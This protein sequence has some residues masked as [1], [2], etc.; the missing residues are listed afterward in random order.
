MAEHVQPHHVHHSLLWSATVAAAVSIV[1]VGRPF[2][3][4]AELDALNYSAAANYTFGNTIQVDSGVASLMAVDQTDDAN[5]A[6]GFDGGSH[7][8][9]EWETGN[10][11]LELAN[12]GLVAGSGVFTSRVIDGLSEVSW[13]TLRW[14]SDRP[15]SKPLPDGA[16]IETAYASG[17]VDM[18]D[19]LLLMHLDGDFVI[20]GQ[21]MVDNSDNSLNGIITTNDGTTN[22]TTAGKIAAAVSLDGVDDVITVPDTALLDETDV[23]TIEAWVDWN[24]PNEVW[25]NT[26]WPQRKEI[27]ISSAA[28][29]DLI[30]FPHL[31]TV[32]YESEMQADYD[33]LRFVSGACDDTGGAVL[34]HEVEDAGVAEAKVWVKLPSL[35]TTTGATVCMYYGDATASNAEDAAGVWDD[36]FEMVLHLNETSGDYI[37][38]T[39]NSNDAAVTGSPTRGAVGKVAGAVEFNNVNNERIATSGVLDT[40]DQFTISTWANLS[41]TGSYQTS[42]WNQATSGGSWRQIIAAHNNGNTYSWFNGGS[43]G[44]N[45]GMNPG[46][47]SWHY[48]VF[49]YDGSDIKV[50]RDGVLQNTLTTQMNNS[51]SL[52]HWAL[53]DREDSS[54]WRTDGVIDEYR[55]STTERDADWITHSYEM[56][57]NAGLHV[58][59]GSAE[60]FAQQVIV[61]KGNDA[62]SLAIE[63]GELVGSVN[64][65]VVSAAFTEGWNHVAL[66]YDQTDLRLFLN[67]TQVDAE[68]LTGLIATNSTDLT[69]GDGLSGELDEVAVYG[70][71]LTPDEVQD[72]YLRNAQQ[73]KFQV[74][75]CDDV[76]C[77]TEPF[78][79]PDGTAA[80]YYTEIESDSLGLPTVTIDVDDNR[81]VQYQ[82]TMG[83]TDPLQNVAVSSV[84]LGPTHYDG[85]R[86]SIV[87]VNATEFVGLSGFVETLGSGSQGS[88]EYQLSA[89]GV[90]WYY[91]NGSAWVVASS[92]SQANSAAAVHSAIGTFASTV[93][94]GS[95]YVQAVLVSADGMQPVELDDISITYT[96]NNSP[97]LSTLPDYILAPGESV[98][99]MLDEYTT[100]ADGDAIAYSLATPTNA[101][102][103]TTSFN[104]DTSQLTITAGDTTGKVTSL[105][106]VATD[107]N[108]AAVTS[109]VVAV[110]VVVEDTVESGE[111]E[112]ET[113]TSP[114][115]PT[116]LRLKK[117]T[118]RKA[119]LRWSDGA[120]DTTPPADYYKVQI[121]AA[122]N[123]AIKADTLLCYEAKVNADCYRIGEQ[124]AK[125]TPNQAYTFAVQACYNSGE[126]SAYSESRSF[127]TKPNRVKDVQFSIIEAEAQIGEASF[128]PA[129]GSGLTYQVQLRN[130]KN[131]KTITA[132]T[133][134]ETTGHLLR[135]PADKK[136][137]LRI[138]AKYNDANVGKWQKQR[139]GAGL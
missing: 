25:F 133:S 16:Q 92:T 101:T 4:Q 64:N 90:T 49:A 81:Y 118:V 19:N 100:D 61:S 136:Y 74:R 93:G 128:S 121:R 105:Q 60:S 41:S 113:A 89:D 104:G 91:Y 34:S 97:V 42:F 10:S 30:D 126:C 14:V 123:T 116:D 37:D 73:L 57:E 40:S 35:T 48:F 69:I 11:R 18:T 111:G 68:V 99:V 58:T 52:D 119:K 33:D 84:E 51:T 6:A 21:T 72:R 122:D 103:A 130:K 94:T 96:T 85:S 134:E 15:T 77:D 3:T 139:V 66:T 67:G 137:T 7:A 117:R 109:N 114:E 110:V 70:R 59:V 12:S 132:I 43:N 54:S 36:D 88:V 50:Y 71:A 13:D 26:A 75:S 131:T 106:V 47:G 78:I 86:P 127:R 108:G 46:M 29:S 45:L 102:V 55:F 27:S 22:K 95:I 82:L 20:N 5:D 8:D 79:G 107:A 9:T 83:T 125:Y 39:G 44:L 120:A 28:S 53:G 56:V 62:Y 23:I 115:V 135:L 1:M 17:N 32:A 76:A 98:T 138:R 124:G 129:D 2:G 24:N 65:T 38:S 112:N 87:N 80:T 31:V 63:G